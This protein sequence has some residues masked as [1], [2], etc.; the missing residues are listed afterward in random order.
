MKLQ[1]GER[2]K[3]DGI[4]VSIAIAGNSSP[5][6]ILPCNGIRMKGKD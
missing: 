2:V 3:I 1:V 5:L 6:I 4:T